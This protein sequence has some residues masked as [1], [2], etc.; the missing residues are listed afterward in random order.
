V[1]AA[2]FDD[3]VDPVQQAKAIV[4]ELKKYDPKLHAKPRWLVFNKLDMVP[5]AEREQRVKDYVKRLRY[6]GPV[7]S[8]SALARD[9]LQPL[10]ESI[11]THVA[12]DQRVDALP[13]QRFDPPPAA[14]DG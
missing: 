14:Q 11:Y 2:P 8:I 5:E 12:K 13:D 10:M 6:K 7:F 4:A 9:G 3:A 1:D